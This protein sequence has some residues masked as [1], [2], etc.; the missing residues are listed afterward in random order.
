MDERH[1][2]ND[3]EMKCS[4]NMCGVSTNDRCNNEEVGDEIGE[5]KKSVSEWMGR[6]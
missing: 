3:M 1:K 4:R 2:L 5:R 6:F